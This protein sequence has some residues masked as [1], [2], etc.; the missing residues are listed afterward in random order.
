MRLSGLTP[1]SLQR[2]VKK[3]EI[4]WDNRERVMTSLS[5]RLEDHIQSSEG[6]PGLAVM[7]NLHQRGSDLIFEGARILDQSFESDEMI[8]LLWQV[9]ED[10]ESW[11]G[12][13]TLLED[14]WTVRFT[15]AL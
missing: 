5:T 15:E 6:R 2:I 3:A 10:V 13:E 12:L 7:E 14:E 1:D 9:K 11:A 8:N 4:S